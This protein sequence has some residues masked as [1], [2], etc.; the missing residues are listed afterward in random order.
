MYVRRRE[1]SCNL[2]ITTV[3]LN[4]CVDDVRQVL[5]DRVKQQE[6]ITRQVGE[7]IRDEAQDRVSHS[8][9]STRSHSLSLS[10]C[11]AIMCTLLELFASA[12]IRIHFNA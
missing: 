12:Q 2:I 9:T 11:E 1:G 10:V 3:T 7:K 6:T 5:K 4:L 8:L